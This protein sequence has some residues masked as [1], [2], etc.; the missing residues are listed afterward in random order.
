MVQATVDLIRRFLWVVRLTPLVHTTPYACGLARQGERT[1][2]RWA[3]SDPSQGFDTTQETKSDS[4]SPTLFVQGERFGWTYHDKRKLRRDFLEPIPLVPPYLPP[5]EEM[6]RLQHARAR[7]KFRVTLSMKFGVAA[8][9]VLACCAGVL[10]SSAGLPRVAIDILATASVLCIAGGAAGAVLVALR[11]FR[12]RASVHE[13][14]AEPQR[15]FEQARESWMSRKGAFEADESSRME[16]IPDWAPAVLPPGNK[17]VDI[18]G[19]TPQGWEAL[20]VVFCSSAVSTC[21]GVIIADLTDETVSQSF[22]AVA[23]AE[24]RSTDMLAVPEMLLSGLFLGL[25]RA[26]IVDMIVQLVHPDDAADRVDRS[27]DRRILDRICSTLGGPISISRIVAALRILLGD[28]EESADLT[29]AERH[30]IANELFGDDYRQ[31]TRGNLIRLESFINPLIGLTCDGDPRPAAD[32][33]CLALDRGH[34]GGHRDAAGSIIVQSLA[35]QVGVHKGWATVVVVGADD[36]PFRQIERL[37]D[38]CERQGVRLVLFFRH[39]RGSVS[40]L[41]GGGSTLAIM[42][43]G[44][45]EEAQR[46]ADFVG[47]QHTF[48]LS[49]VTRT[50]GGN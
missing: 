34:H 30:V 45:H 11:F 12:L 38:S 42:R 33:T 18:V 20:L 22:L 16:A 43:L 32:V 40:Q 29:E 31:Q 39:L 9:V 14:L 44:N 36:V 17:R 8:G 25:A 46:A 5:V 23:A 6:Q 28:S 24:R 37:S 47:R 50:L 10:T 35:R 27:V 19:G 13:A 2:G 4:V 26:D 1:G 41:L 7:L 21:G 15:R 49:E 3:M 48:V